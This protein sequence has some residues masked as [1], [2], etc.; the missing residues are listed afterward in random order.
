MQASTT[1]ETMDLIKDLQS[2]PLG[3]AFG[4]ALEKSFTQALGLVFYDLQPYALKLY[5][6]ITPLRNT[7]PRIV[8]RGGSATN[9][10]AITGI[11][12][13]NISGGVSEGNRGGAIATQTK[14]YVASYKGLGFEDFVTFEADYASENFDDVKARAAEGLLRSTMIYEEKTI[15]GGNASTGLG[16]APAPTLV[17]AATGGTLT[18]VAYTVQVAALTLE[19]YLAATIAGGIPLGISRTNTDASVD[20]YGGGSSQASPTATATPAANGTITATVAPVAGAVAYAW[21]WGT[22]GTA[23]LGAITTVNTVVI[24]AAA[25]GTQLASAASA[26]NSQNQL[27]FDG[28]LP[29]VYAPGSGSTIVTLGAGGNTGGN[30]TLTGDGAGGVV[31]IDQALRAFWD[32]YRLSPDLMLVNSQELLNITR[33]VLAA[34]SSAAPLFR[35]AVDG[36]GQTITAG[37]IIGNY[38]NKYT[39][40][41]GQLVQVMLHPNVPPGT[42]LFVSRTI[43]YPLSNVS[44]VLQMK[45]RRDYYQLEWPLRTRRYEY[46]VYADEVLQNYFPPAFGVVRN[47]QNG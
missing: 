19:G 37:A 15:I 46:G 9:W 21:F 44:N 27:V 6:V 5:P 13:T 34:G 18:N 7:I 31:E 24:A 4:S 2:K 1:Q 23:V 33:R 47:I 29:Q 30:T 14:S 26:D 22:G 43:P 11:N 45:C 35:F 40:S 16:Q 17:T 10:K 38:L 20:T 32:N 12:I 41:G 8:G 25:A 3:D 39:M 42:I 36:G 28:L